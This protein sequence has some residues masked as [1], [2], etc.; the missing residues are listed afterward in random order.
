MS[1]NKRLKFLG[2]TMWRNA[3]PEAEQ[4]RALALANQSQFATEEGT[5]LKAPGIV[6]DAALVTGDGNTQSLRDLI[7]GKPAVLLFF[8]GS[9]CPYST[10]SMRA[11][12]PVRA[13]LAQHGIAM[14]GI[15]PQRHITLAAAIARNAL[16]YPLAHRSRTRRL[17]KQWASASPIIPEMIDMYECQGYDLAKLNESG[18]W[19][20]PLEATFLCR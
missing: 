19:S 20:L 8:R 10:T 1:L 15:T 5:I 3:G 12:E 18:D 6:P 11:Y 4:T 13:D 17:R 2:E 16:G 7:A 9:W 14:I